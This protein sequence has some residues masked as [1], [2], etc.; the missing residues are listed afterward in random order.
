ML[1][2]QVVTVKLGLEDSEGELEEESEAEVVTEEV[3]EGD[4]ETEML[5]EEVKRADSVTV[6]LDERERV[7]GREAELQA[8]LVIV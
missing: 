8:D 4:M 1:V 3:A 2:E 6:A 5:R 7:G